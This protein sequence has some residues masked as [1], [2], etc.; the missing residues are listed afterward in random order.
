MTVLLSK[1]SLLL[2]FNCPQTVI[3]N[4]TPNWTPI[5]QKSLEG[6]QARCEQLYKASPCLKSFIKM[7][8]QEYRAICYTG[9]ILVKLDKP[10]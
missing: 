8:F 6:A 7:D 3:T 2:A 10:L 4:H 5:D 9:A 1:I